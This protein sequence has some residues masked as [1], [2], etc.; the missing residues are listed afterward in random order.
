MLPALA[1]PSFVSLTAKGLGLASLVGLGAGGLSSAM[2]Y[3]KQR[4]AEIVRAGKDNVT[5]EFDTNFLDD[6]LIDTSKESL[7]GSADKLTMDEAK[8]NPLV[9]QAQR[10]DS[11]LQLTT[12]M[13]ADDFLSTYASDINRTKIKKDAENALLVEGMQFNSPEAKRRRDLEDDRFKFLQTQY[14]DARKDAVTARQEDRLD[15][16][17]GFTQQLRILQMQQDADQARYDQNLQLYKADQKQ[18]QVNNLV[19]GL[20]ALG[21]AFAV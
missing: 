20:V 10:D 17:D 6:L 9:K 21:A 11:S 12:G 13:T 5:G 18:N 3:P 8:K 19:A 2:K 1:I 7:Q 15:R 16:Q 14:N 4:R